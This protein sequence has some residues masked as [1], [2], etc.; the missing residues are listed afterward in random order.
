MYNDSLAI[1]FTCSLTDGPRFN[2]HFRWLKLYLT[3]FGGWHVPCLPTRCCRNRVFSYGFIVCLLRWTRFGALA[4]LS[5]FGIDFDIVPAIFWSQSYIM[6]LVFLG[7]GLL[8]LSLQ[9]RVVQRQMSFDERRNIH[10]AADLAKRSE[11]RAKIAIFLL[12]IAEAIIFWVAT[13]EFL[14]QEIRQFLSV[15]VSPI[16]VGCFGW[17]AGSLGLIS[18]NALKKIFAAQPSE[19]A[20]KIPARMT[21]LVI[22]YSVACFLG[23]TVAVAGGV[24]AAL[25]G[26]EETPAFLV[27]SYPFRFMEVVALASL[28]IVYRVP[29]AA[30][31]QSLE[32]LRNK[33][34]GRTSFA[35]KLSKRSDKSKSSGASTSKSTAALIADDTEI[36][37]A[38]P[39][40]AEEP[41]NA[42]PEAAPEAPEVPETPPAPAANDEAEPAAPPAPTMEE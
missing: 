21:K 35:S 13:T 11:S 23:G 19:T 7:A 38:T 40:P 10:E 2:D 3:F 33:A 32:K 18:G 15:T 42:A 41:S 6:P 4:G 17:G 16:L 37:P 26:Q 39:T 1:L 27:K 24:L 5:V 20:T 9:W 28:V 22:R 31:E 36:T 34:D 29:Q 8:T 12:F 30:V 25:R 14:T